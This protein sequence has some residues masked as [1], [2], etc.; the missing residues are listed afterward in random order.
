MAKNLQSYGTEIQELFLRFLITDD[1]LF[2][3]SR[4][5]NRFTIFFT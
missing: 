1:Q 2:A 5:I 4:N 3:R